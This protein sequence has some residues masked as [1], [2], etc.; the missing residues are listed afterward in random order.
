MDYNVSINGDLFPIQ[1]GFEAAVSSYVER[2]VEW[3][4]ITQNAAIFYQFQTRDDFEQ[5]IRV[6]PDGCLDFVFCCSPI[7]P[8]AIIYGKKLKSRLITLESGCNFFGFRPMSEQG[9][10]PKD[11]SMIEI[12]NDEIPFLKAFP[13]EYIIETLIKAESFEQRIRIFKKYLQNKLIDKDFKKNLGHY[14]FSQICAS[15]G[16]IKIEDLARRTGYSERY[17]RKK[18]EDEYGVSPKKFGQIVMFQNSLNMLMKKN[19]SKLD[20]VFENGYYDQSHLIH[21]FKKL[22]DVAPNEFKNMIDGY[23]AHS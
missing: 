20:I 13:D 8:S 11:F 7:R 6:V 14:C 19:H 22:A 10:K 5:K 4:P 12:V 1:P 9:L 16:T 23:C 15:K 18:Y 3:N 17:M 2:V 21:H